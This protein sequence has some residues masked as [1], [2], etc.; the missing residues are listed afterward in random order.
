MSK[1]SDT[2]GWVCELNDEADDA[3]PLIDE[4]EEE[5]LL[6]SVGEDGGDEYPNTGN[7]VDWYSE[8][9]DLRSRVLSEGID[10]GS[11]TTFVSHVSDQSGTLSYP[12]TARRD[13]LNRG[14]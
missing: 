1:V 3:K 10:D 14:E 13:R 9:L 7:D 4:E 5:S 2:G 11:E 12:L 6:E 8:K